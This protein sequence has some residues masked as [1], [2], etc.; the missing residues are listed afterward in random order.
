[1]TEHPVTPT[2]AP[3]ADIPAP[4]ERELDELAP[5]ED[6]REPGAAVMDDRPEE[7]EDG[8]DPDAQ[9]EPA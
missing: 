4:E 6:E 8:P 9:G 3:D 2:D 7:P 1:M 5:G